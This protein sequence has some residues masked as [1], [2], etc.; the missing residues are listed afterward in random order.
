MLECN[1]IRR[2]TDNRYEIRDVSVTKFILLESVITNF[3]IKFIFLDKVYTFI[4]HK[5]STL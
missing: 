4:R 3:F 2:V 1:L 5:K